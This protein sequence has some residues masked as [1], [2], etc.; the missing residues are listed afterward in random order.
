MTLFLL[1]TNHLSPLV[2]LTHP[3][4]QRVQE[5][6][7]SG[8][9]FAIPT[10]ALTEF[11]FG[12]GTLPRARQN[13]NAWQA[14]ADS[15]TYYNVERQDAEEAAELRL[16]LR[17]TG[18]QLAAVDALIAVLALRNDLILLTNDGD[19]AAIPGIKLENWR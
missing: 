19:F 13:Q 14:I 3:L 7:D 4:R 12:I 2:T 1:D 6:I 16:N 11:L 8:D 9:S 15:F 5:Q 18:H 10:P 17:R